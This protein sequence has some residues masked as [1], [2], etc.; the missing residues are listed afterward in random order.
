MKLSI[1]RKSSV[2]IILAALAA[3]PCWAQE[4]TVHE[5]DYAKR[6]DNYSPYV[7]QH[8]PQ[9]VYFGDDV[10][11]S[12]RFVDIVS[13]L[14]DGRTHLDLRRFHDTDPIRSTRQDNDP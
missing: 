2:W 13:R 3:F 12:Q 11:W 7:D 10:Q 1:P 8:F 14:P 4:F 6:E 5:D 9:N